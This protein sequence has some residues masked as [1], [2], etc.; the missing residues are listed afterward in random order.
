MFKLVCINNIYFVFYC[1]YGV[2]QSTHRE[3][4]LPYALFQKENLYTLNHLKAKVVD[5]TKCMWLTYL[6]LKKI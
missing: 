3:F 4:V 1:K 2:G 5:C 6:T